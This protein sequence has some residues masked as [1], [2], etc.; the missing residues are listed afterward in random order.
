MNKETNPMNIWM[1]LYKIKYILLVIILFPLIFILFKGYSIE[2]PYFKIGRVPDT[3]FIEKKIK[4][5]ADTIYKEKIVTKYIEVPKKDK[6]IKVKNLETEVLVNNKPANINT[7]TNNG[8]L[9]NNNT[10][11]NINE[12]PIKLNELDKKNILLVVNSTFDEIPN[13]IKKEIKITAMLGNARSI[14]LA[15]LIEEFLKKKGFTISDFS[16]GMFSKTFKGLR[17]FQEK[18]FV[19]INIGII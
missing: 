1:F 3:L 14:Q 6:S 18:N 2:T 15:E 10:I 5:P 13:R 12:K 17:V 11:N 19:K 7:G 8:I 16:Q 9:G 4:I